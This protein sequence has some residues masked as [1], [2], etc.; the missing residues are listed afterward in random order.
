M[1]RILSALIAAAMIFS[2][3]S[4]NVAVAASQLTFT[5][6]SVVG[7]R[8]DT[9]EFTVDISG[10]VSPGLTGATVIINFDKDKFEAVSIAKYSGAFPELM[11]TKGNVNSANNTGVWRSPFAGSDGDVYNGTLVTAKF[12][13]K[14]NVDF[15]D[16]EIVLSCT[17]NDENGAAIT[18]GIV[19][20]NGKITVD[21]IN[22]KTEGVDWTITEDPKCEDP[23]EKVKYCSV[24]SDIAETEAIDPLGH[25]WGAWEETTAPG[26][27]SY[28]E[29]E[30]ICNRDHNH[31]ETQSID[32]NG[33][34]WT[35]CCDSEC[36]TCGETR[37][38]PHDWNAEKTYDNDNHWI[39]CSKCS[40][41]K[42]IAA[43]EYD[44][45]C[46]ATCDCGNTRVPPHD[47]KTELTHDD[48]SHWIEC[49]KCSEKK[50]IEK[51]FIDASGE[52]TYDE[53]T[54]TI[55]GKCCC[56]V[57]VENTTGPLFIVSNT[58]GQAEDT[59]EVTVSLAKNTGVAGLKFNIGFDKTL[60]ELVSANVNNELLSEFL[61]IK[62][63]I[64]DAN[65]NGEWSLTGACIVNALG[66]GDLVTLTF[67]IKADAPE[68]FTDI[69]LSVLEFVDSPTVDSPVDN[70]IASSVFVI[71]GEVEIY[72]GIPG[73]VD[74]NGE[75]DTTDAIAILRFYAGYP[76]D[77][78]NEALADFDGSG[79]ID[80]TD[81]IAVL[82]LYAGY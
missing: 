66:E 81:A 3:C 37:V 70:D 11:F 17:A 2:L 31:K 1:K 33:H 29:E 50:D 22:H 77:N 40:E 80:T 74:E 49:S 71:D 18:S 60:L 76:V 42:D 75:V 68:C 8:G 25:D 62:G 78:F 9:V 58:K 65:L 4:I 5:G 38:P 61:F 43:H 53:E 47:W 82:R 41:K 46:D 14:D 16:Y 73:D 55:F 30:R 54:E 13:I 79:E 6:S 27:V 21:C 51:H 59:I 56:G 26:C 32:P 67:K 45:C 34:A 57:D 64:A 35:D 72:E 36:N 69:T 12:K 19:N 44:D 28:G 52:W 23:G 15:G 39:E 63:D 20:V 10:V 48:E 24:C 7:E